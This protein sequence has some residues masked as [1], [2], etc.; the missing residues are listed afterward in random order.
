MPPAIY[1]AI[2]LILLLVGACAPQGLDQRNQAELVSHISRSLKDL[3]AISDRPACP[4]TRLKNIGLRRLYCTVSPQLPYA[5][6]ENLLGE[7]V[8]LN[9]PHQDGQLNL[10]H[11]SQFGHYNPKFL[12]KFSNALK[13]L[14][15]NDTFVARTRLFHNRML[16]DIIDPYLASYSYIELHRADAWLINALDVKLGKAEPAYG[17]WQDS[18]DQYELRTET[19]QPLPYGWAQERLRDAT[20]ALA[21]PQ[22]NDCFYNINTAMA[23]WLRR[24]IDGTDDQFLALAEMLQQAYRP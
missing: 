19:N 24:S 17:S 21:T 12:I 8:F 7:P 18:V 16:K 2:L 23:F 3:S 4:S 11:A 9:G 13:S 1:E 20:V 5:L 10:A 22:C 14:L 6:V 15:D